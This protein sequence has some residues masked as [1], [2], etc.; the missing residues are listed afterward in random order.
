VYF[1]VQIRIF[2]SPAIFSVESGLFSFTSGVHNVTD[3]IGSWF[4]SKKTLENTIALLEEENARISNELAEKNA[5]LLS[6]DDA[7]KSDTRLIPGT[8]EVSALFSPLTSL[9]QSFLISKGFSS[10]IEEGAI[11]Y[12]PGYIPIGTVVK[13]GTHTSEVKLLS[14]PGNELE[15]I[16]VGSSTDKVILRLTGIGGGDYSALL[17]KETQIAIGDTVMWKDNPKMTLGTVVG[18]DNEP[19]AIAQKLLVRGTYSATNATHLFI[20]TQ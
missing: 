3:S 2:F 6:Y 12:A 11:V 8:L 13:V 16:V 14:A 1:W 15:G 17:P 20:D 7:Y 5:Q 4:S 9:Y 10:E 19:Q 18:I